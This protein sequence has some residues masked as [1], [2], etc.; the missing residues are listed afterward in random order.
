LTGI[1]KQV[2]QWI[3]RCQRIGISPLLFLFQELNAAGLTMRRPSD[4]LVPLLIAGIIFQPIAHLHAADPAAPSTSALDL[5]YIPADAVAAVVAQP[6]QLLTGPQGDLYPTEVLSLLGKKHAGFDPLT[7]QQAITVIGVPDPNATTR[8]PQPRA[9]FVLRFAAPIDLLTVTTK[10]VPSGRDVDINAAKARIAP[11]PQD[12]SCAVLDNRVLIIANETDLHW[13]LSAQPGDSPLRKLMAAANTAPL[14][15]AFL[16]LEPLRPMLAPAMSHA[17]QQLPPPLQGFTKIPDLID[18]VTLTTQQNPTGG[19]ETNL[20]FAALNEA[21]ARE[22]EGQLRGALEMG[23]AAFLAQMSSDMAKNSG[24]DPEISSAM[25]RYMGRLSEK[26][27]AALQPV[28]DGN[29]V[30]FHFI[31]PAGPAVIGV[32][33]ALLLPAVQAAREAARRVQS[34]NNLKQIAL[35][36]LNYEDTK[37]HLPARANFDA[38]GKP[39]LSWRVHILPFLEEDELYKQFHLDEPWDSDHN[40]QLIDKM[41]AIYQHPGFDSPSPGLTLYQA[42]AGPGC[43]FEGNEGTTLKSFTDGTSRTIVVVEAAKSKA[44][45]W[46]KP[47]D[48]EMDP[49]NPLRGLGGIFPGGVFNAL[50]ADGHVDAISDTINPAIFKALLTRNG[51]EAVGQGY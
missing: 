9:G 42:V 21:D 16:A 4:L 20:V 3:E 29:R 24:D 39:L 17:A 51:G 38:N 48:W 15:Q 7:I 5:T 8:D 31:A 36:L 18:T 19:L 23:R 50:F 49:K 35:A 13:I 11:R 12:M 46:T 25:M 22:L 44:V 14:A 10:L 34:S 32:L 2:R 1:K 45:P 26:T 28:R 30:K 43:A 27:L 40:K 37:H 41:P 33:F 47:E 6:G